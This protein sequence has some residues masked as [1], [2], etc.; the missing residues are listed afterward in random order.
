MFENIKK[1][2]LFFFTLFLL[3]A[4][5]F[6]FYL[7][8]R[9]SNRKLTFAML[10]IGQGDALFIESPTGTQILIDGGP[11][12]KILSQLARVMPP[13]DRKIDALIITNPDAD[14][15]GGFADVLKL[16]D[17]DYVFEPGTFNESKTYQ[18]LK[19]EI[20]KKNIKNI[21]ARRGMRIHLGGGA[22]IDSLLP[23]RDGSDWTT[24]DGSVAGKLTFGETE[25]ML[26]GDGTKETEKIILAD[27]ATESLDV[28][29][30][31]VGHHGSKT[32]TSQA[33]VQALSPGYALIS[34]G[35]DNNYGHPYQATLDVLASV[36]AK[37]LRTDLDGTIVFICDRIEPCAIKKS[38]N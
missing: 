27:N 2:G 21:L 37:I 3:C 25:I 31:K 15:I 34:L 26:M 28:D 14:H 5:I 10:D 32:S 11:P 13:F 36:G 29:I 20:E 9:G 35:K 24:N 33:F 23:D 12:R 4:T 16:Y 22:G 7:D 8:F 1:Y 18:N 19:T 38:K 30:L 17:V 6:I